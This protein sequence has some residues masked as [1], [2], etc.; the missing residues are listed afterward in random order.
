MLLG[1]ALIALRAGAV[2]MSWSDFFALLLGREN[3]DP[4][5]QTVL[6]EL[7]LPRVLFAI[8]VGGALALSGT[9]MQ[10]LFRN[11]LAEP[12]LIGISAGA[13]LGAVTALMLGFGSVLATGFAGFAGAIIATFSAY[14]IGRR[15][16]GVAGLLLAGIAINAFALSL[17]S[18][19]ITFASDTQFR[20]FSFWSL[21]SLTRASWPGLVWLLPWSVLISLWLISRWRV[22]NALLLGEREALH[23]G[24][25]LNRVRR[26]LII[27]ICLLVGPLVAVT[28]GIAFIGL[29]M[30]HI[31]RRWL[32]ADHRL[33][34]PMSWLGG[35]MALLLADGLARLVVMPAELPVGV[36][37]SLVGGPF[38]LWLLLRGT[39]RKL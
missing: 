1:W 10:A 23:L 37:T 17:V 5:L 29:V 13:S 27:A 3:V 22:L 8:I 12:T 15:D 25:A 32:G 20:S 26:E 11:P 39:P 33:L 36:I 30:P 21:G 4:L 34:L 28:G 35:A 6:F 16:P 14:L 9:V 31:L 19:L 7:R 38:F 24:F 18:V 2:D